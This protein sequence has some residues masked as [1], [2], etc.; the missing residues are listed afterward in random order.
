MQS[1][2]AIGAAT[3]PSLVFSLGF[4]PGQDGLVSSYSSAR[5]VVLNGKW[6]RKKIMDNNTV[7]H[8]VLKVFM[9]RD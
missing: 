6:R 5:E 9:S 4:P 2:T 3:K 8:S 1:P 7:A